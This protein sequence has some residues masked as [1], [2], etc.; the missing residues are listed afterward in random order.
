MIE[1]DTKHKLYLALKSI[2]EHFAKQQ[3]KKLSGIFMSPEALEYLRKW[4]EDD[5]RKRTT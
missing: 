1:N 3:R 2:K 4:G 5:D